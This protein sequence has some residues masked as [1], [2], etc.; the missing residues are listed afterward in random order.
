MPGLSHMI[1][2]VF[3][4]LMLEWSEVIL[5]KA[6]SMHY[7]VYNEDILKKCF[8]SSELIVT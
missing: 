4:I 7:W 1:C 3:V 6:I 5:N 2:F 8:R